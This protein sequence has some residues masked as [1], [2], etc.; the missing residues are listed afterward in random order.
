MTADLERRADWGLGFC[1]LRP[2][3][4]GTWVAIRQHATVLH[5]GRAMSKEGRWSEGREDEKGSS[6]WWWRFQKASTA[7]TK[8]RGRRTKLNSGRRPGAGGSPDMKAAT[9]P[10]VKGVGRN[11]HKTCMRGGEETQVVHG[12]DKRMVSPN[13]DSPLLSPRERPRGTGTFHSKTNLFP[14][15]PTFSYNVRREFF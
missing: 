4:G 10:S 13:G 9:G 15:F 6:S 5:R 2:C 1:S 11:G 7:L 8:T 3:T 12:L 14:P